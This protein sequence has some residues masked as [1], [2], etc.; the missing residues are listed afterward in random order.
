MRGNTR[1]FFWQKRRAEFNHDFMKNRFLPALA[2][3]LN[4]LDDQLHDP[5]LE[6]TF[7]ISV[8]PAWECARRQAV[9]LVKELEVEMSPA[10]YFDEIPLS[11]CNVTSK[12]WLADLVH[13]LWLAKWGVRQRVEETLR[14]IAAAEEAYQGI[15]RA[16]G[17]GGATKELRAQRPIFELFRI[18]CIRI[19]ESV[20]SL[21]RLG[22]IAPSGTADSNQ[23]SKA[24]T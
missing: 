6:E 20:E 18:R 19:A 23:G 24:G 15:L 10:R 21:G 2:R 14:A 12:A 7:L 1:A 5:H 17:E 11:R 16:N 8:L 3:W 9:G 22:P 13:E 4:L